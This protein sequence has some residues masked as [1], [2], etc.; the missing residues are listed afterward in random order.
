MAIIPR[1]HQEIVE[2]VCMFEKELSTSFMKLEVHPVIHLVDDVELVGVVSCR[3]MF[4][5]ERYM[6]K[7]KGFVRQREKLEGSM[8]EGYILYESFYYASEHIK[9]IYNRPG[10]VIWDDER[11][12]DKRE[13]ELLQMSGKSA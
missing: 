4:F 5:L 11:D 3:W 7:L 1:W 9:Q 13:G 12:E 8:A 6:K 2:I 10:A